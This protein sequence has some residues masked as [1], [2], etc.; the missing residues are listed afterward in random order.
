MLELSI[1]NH[2]AHFVEAVRAMSNQFEQDTRTEVKLRV[3]EWRDAWADLVKVALYSDG[4]HV[5]EIGNTWLSEFV[6]MNALRPFVGGEVSRI[7]GAHQFLPSAWQSVTPTTHT[8]AAALTW[9]MPWLADMRLIHYRQDILDRAGVDSST[10][11]QTPDALLQTC[12]R[13]QA[14]GVANP[15]VVPSR[16][17]LMTLHNLAAWVWGTGGDFTPPDGKKVLFASAQAKAGIYAYFDLARYM[18]AEVRNRDE[19]QSDMAFLSGQAAMTISGPWLHQSPDMPREIAAQ[20]RQALPPGVPYIGGSHLVVWKHT[21]QAEPALTLVQ[22]LSSLEAQARFVQTSGLFP[23]RLEVLTREPFNSDPFYQ[24]AG[25]GLK[26]GR[27]FPTFSLW[28][29]M[30]NKLTEAFTEIWADILLTPEADIHAI[31][32]DHLNDAAQRL[33]STLAYY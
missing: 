27:A 3:L 19:N 11:F 32:D 29:L 9:A 23:S 14:A 12:A 16:Q 15:V 20:T 5:S 8:R 2:G 7:G 26:V 6:S 18:P 1:M 30:E 13:L 31:V 17:S 4:P 25:A 22:Y 33:G 10:A 24:M 21:R 28:G